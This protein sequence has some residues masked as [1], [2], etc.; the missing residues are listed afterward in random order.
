MERSETGLDL[1]HEVSVDAKTSFQELHE[2]EG[3]KGRSSLVSTIAPDNRTRPNRECTV[4]EELE[5]QPAESGPKRS[6]ACSI[7][8]EAGVPGRKKRA[9]CGSVNKASM[10]RKR[11]KVMCDQ[12]PRCDRSALCQWPV[13]LRWWLMTA[14]A[15]GCKVNC[16]GAPVGEFVVRWKGQGTPDPRSALTLPRRRPQNPTRRPRAR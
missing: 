2:E 14:V 4:L 9:M 7:R 16:P 12:R 11:K 8:R 3:G 5:S 15:R 1:S 13:R 10:R 6:K